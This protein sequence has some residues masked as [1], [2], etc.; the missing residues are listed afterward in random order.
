MK[1]DTAPDVER[2][3]RDWMAVQSGADRV[4]MACDMFD[5][6]VALAIASLPPEVANDPVERRIALLKRFY[7]LDV[8]SDFLARVIEDVRGCGSL[9]TE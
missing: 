4:R 1:S 3:L 2:R 8:D 6:A 5:T 7:E 9:T